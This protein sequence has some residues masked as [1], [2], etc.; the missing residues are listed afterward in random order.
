LTNDFGLSYDVNSLKKIGK[1][2]DAAQNVVSGQN[3]QS[4]P[5]NL[6]QPN[7]DLPQAVIPPPPPG[8]QNSPVNQPTPSVPPVP[9]P[10]PVE[11]PVVPPPPN[12]PTIEPLPQKLPP[13][14]EPGLPPKEKSDTKGKILMTTGPL[15]MI[16]SLA[17]S[18]YL[19]KNAPSRSTSLAP[20]VTQHQT[21][22][23]YLQELPQDNFTSVLVNSPTNP[24]KVTVRCEDTQEEIQSEVPTSCS[25][26]VF[27]WEGE[28]ANEPG[29]NIIAYYAYLGE[30]N[31][32]P[33][34]TIQSDSSELRR[35]IKP[36]TQGFYTSEK[37]YTASNLEKGKTYYFAVQAVSDSHNPN[38]RVG[39]S[40]VDL[41]QIGA[42]IAK[43][44]FV[45]KYE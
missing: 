45:L 38:Y 22:Q 44:L 9:T 17:T 10:S 2:M 15:L 1:I 25:R 35:A 14:E 39:F 28:R 29:T 40:Q 8:I 21:Y 23:Q 13:K 19:F 7:N 16:L 32:E 42:Q 37:S 41:E 3:N 26:P 31:Y 11:P 5:A 24:D 6:G 27:T 34:I 43:V 30:N 18:F 20:A 12:I 33:M 4:Q 36:E